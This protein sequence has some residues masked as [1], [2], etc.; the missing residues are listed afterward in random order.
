MIHSSVGDL[1]AISS[2][3]Y[4]FGFKGGNN[5]FDRL[6]LSGFNFLN[7]L[8]T[9]W[10]IFDALLA[11]GTI[12]EAGGVFSFGLDTTKINLVVEETGQSVVVR[13]YG[14]E[15]SSLTADDFIFV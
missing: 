9:K 3:P 10:E 14:T 7:G 11:A 13:L 12:K 6:H 5:S 2:Y 15:L 8:N 1:A 4:I